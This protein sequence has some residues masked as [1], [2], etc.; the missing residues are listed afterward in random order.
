MDQAK[1]QKAAYKDRVAK[2]GPIC[3]IIDQRWNNQLHRPIHA[4]GFFLNPKY[5]YK[6]L[7]EEVLTR[8]LRDAQWWEPFGSQCPQLQK[9]AIRI[10]SQT[11]SASGCKHNWFVFERIHMK[12]RNR[13]EQK[14]LND[15]VFIQ[16]NPQ[17]RRNQ[18]LNKIP[19]TDPIVL[20]DI[21][22]SSDWV[23]ETQPA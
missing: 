22:P 11:C 15:L 7:A 21:D 9:F 5:H 13:L 1:E 23:V 20:E 4:A 12:K 19:N 18:L 3:E 16:Y 6:A 17:L 8:E 2:Y 10:L 14:W